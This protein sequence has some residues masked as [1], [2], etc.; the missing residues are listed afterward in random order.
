MYPKINIRGEKMDYNVLVGGAAGQGMETITSIIEK[1]LKRA[2]LEIFTIR[3]YMSRVRGGHNFT[4]IRFSERKVTSHKDKLNGIIAFNTET[5]SYHVERLEDEGFIIADESVG[6]K[7]KRLKK[8]P[9]VKIA[10]EIGNPRVFGSVA[11]GAL[12]KLYNIDISFLEEVLKET[13][14]NEI[15]SLNIE[16]V[17]RG[18]ALVDSLY[19]I[20]PSGKDDNILIDGNDA[21]ALG[22]IA[23]G[24]KFYSAYPMTPSTSIMNYLARKMYE[25]K[26]VVEQAEDEIAAINMAI[27][28]SYAGVRAMT[29]TSGGGFSLMVEALGLA[30]M[31]EIPLVI[32]E[33]QR[34]GPATGLPT[35]TEQSDLKFI[36][37]ASHGEFPRMV[38]ALKNPEDCF[39]QTVRAF[40]IADK[41]RIPVVILGDQFLADF[42]TTIK[43]FDLSKL[44]INRY[45]NHEEYMDGNKEYKTYEMTKNGISPRIIPGKIKGTRVLVD[46]DEHDEY[47]QITESSEVR[48]NM[49]DKRLNKMEFLKEELIEPS[50][51]GASQPDVLLLGWGSVE[52]PIKEAVELLNKN[53]NRN[54]AALVFGD[55]WPLPVKMLN[56][57]HKKA[58]TIINV[59]QNATGQ[60]ASVIRA[61]TGIKCHSSILKYDGRPISA[62]EIYNKLMEVN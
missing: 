23:A 20:D 6:Y 56:E 5:I 55:I 17:K 60:L 51:Y 40:N 58:K 47:G 1:S 22:V 43:P 9:L 25:A 24:C 36:I 53:G 12:F 38:I 33:I 62:D 27:G 21:I 39:Y 14:K 42:T 45:F 10:K 44:E 35:R 29:G 11:G 41:Y 61:E 50:F 16:A 18:N 52:G 54:Y 8:L 31:Q 49:C 34:P 2:G 57:M 28:A 59:E 30:G 48:K 15:A 37:S 7:D 19:S 4:Q 3:D 46:S 13:F 32:A 26:I